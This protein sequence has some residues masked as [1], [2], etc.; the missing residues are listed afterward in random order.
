MLVTGSPYCCS[1]SCA[2]A[3]NEEFPEFGCARFAPVPVAASALETAL[4]DAV[5]ISAWRFAPTA[6]SRL[7]RASEIAF[8]SVALA[9]V[10]FAE[11]VSPAE[12]WQIGRLSE[13]LRVAGGAGLAAAGVGWPEFSLGGAGGGTT[14]AGC[15]I[16]TF[17]VD[18]ISD[19]AL[20]VDAVADVAVAVAA[21][22]VE[23]RCA[24]PARPEATCDA[25]TVAADPAADETIVASSASAADRASL[26]PAATLTFPSSAV[27]CV[28]PAGVEPKSSA[29]SV[30]VDAAVIAILSSAASS[31]ELGPER[32]AL[33]GNAG[34]A[35]ATTACAA[36]AAF[37]VAGESDAADKKFGASAAGGGSGEGTGGANGA[38]A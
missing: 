8:C 36:V 14:K 3:L 2:P 11:T 24:A 9:V 27:L 15:G 23:S 6:C 17:A 34:T 37:S 5:L 13:A 7:S 35:E 38:A 32:I 21:A 33:V 30:A 18:S 31:G 16:S 22:V 28:V 26:A 1:R 12:V 29:A 19:V 4:P 10:K 20:A 25:L